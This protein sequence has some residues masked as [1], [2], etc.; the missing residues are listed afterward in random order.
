MSRSQSG[1]AIHM[2]LKRQID[3]LMDP[4]YRAEVSFWKDDE[5]RYGRR[6]GI[7]VDVIENAGRRLACVYDIKTG[8]SRGSG[9][10]PRR[11]AEIAEHVLRVYPHVQRIIVTEVRPTR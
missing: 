6:D 4:N 11:M 2:H 5:D 3:S 7:R 1:T 8:Q 9:L 10:S